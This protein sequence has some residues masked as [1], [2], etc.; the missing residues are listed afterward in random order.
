MAVVGVGIDVVDVARMREALAGP[1]GNRLRQ[2]VFTAV[3]RADCERQP[4]LSAARY[5]SRFAAKEAV[6]KSL[7]RQARLGFAWPD[8]EIA[9]NAAGAPEVRLHGR[10]AERARGLG[11]RR[12]LVSLAHEASVAVA[13]A[14][15]ES[16][17]E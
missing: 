9:R 8:V 12:V 10:A 3:E 17:A 4:A 14:I 16:T 1:R 6:L 2:R 13:Q 5:A 7:G 11:A 15:A